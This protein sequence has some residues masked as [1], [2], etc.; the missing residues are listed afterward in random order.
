MGG[1]TERHGVPAPKYEW[2]M[3]YADTGELFMHFTVK[4]GGETFSIEACKF[5]EVAYK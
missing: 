3:L 4:R 5:P 2:E 1:L